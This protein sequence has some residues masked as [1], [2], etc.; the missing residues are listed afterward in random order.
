MLGEFTEPMCSRSNC[1]GHTE[2]IT[3]LELGLV[4]LLCLVCTNRTILA[5]FKGIEDEEEHECPE[6]GHEF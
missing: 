3:D 1:G 4:I 5:E 6:C 2:V